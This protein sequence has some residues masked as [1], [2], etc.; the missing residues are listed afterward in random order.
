MKKYSYLLGLFLVTTCIIW[1]CSDD[2]PNTTNP[3]GSDGF[4][5]QLMLTN[6]TD[7]I[8]VPAFQAVNTEVTALKSAADAFETDATQTNFNALRSAWESAYIAWQQVDMFVHGPVED[9]AYITDRVSFINAY[10]TNSGSIDTFITSGSYDLTAN[11]TSDEQG[12]PALD[13]LLYG[14]ADNDTDILAF[15]TGTNASNYLN[16]LTDVTDRLQSLVAQIEAQWS[17]TYRTSFINN[18]GS[19]SSSSVDLFTNDWLRYFEL[20]F[21]NGKIGIP[22][23]NFTATQSGNPEPEKVEAF[24]RKDLSKT[25]A[26]TAINAFKDFFK[27]NHFGSNGTGAS[28]EDYLNFVN[29]V[30]GTSAVSDAINTQLDATISAINDLDNN[31]YN[32]INTNNSAMSSV[33]DV[34]QANVVFIKV[35]MLSALSIDVLFQSGDGD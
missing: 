29:G 9:I 34:I 28:F 2:D 5:R 21:R 19:S 13:Y 11:N 8:I 24:Y 18:S 23:G 15:Y 14:L 30:S 35:D 16:Y 6:W 1:S 10:P 32:Q 25:L 31:F 22:S 33:Y 7:N 27:G 12:F 4:D 26:L 17:G 3:S 20:I